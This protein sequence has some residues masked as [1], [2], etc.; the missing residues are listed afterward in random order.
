MYLH[1]SL[2]LYEFFNKFQIVITCRILSTLRSG[3]YIRL[4]D[5][6]KWAWVNRSILYAYVDVV[7]GITLRVSFPN[8]L[9]TN[10]YI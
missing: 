2:R 1:F 7:N 9:W 3:L 5:V 4:L 6:R 10:P 8:Y